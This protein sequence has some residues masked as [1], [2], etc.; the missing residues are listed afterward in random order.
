MTTQAHSQYLDRLAQRIPHSHVVNYVIF[1]RKIFLWKSYGKYPVTGKIYYCINHS[2]AAIDIVTYIVSCNYNAPMSSKTNAFLSVFIA[3]TWTQCTYCTSLLLLVHLSP[4]L[5]N[6]RV[7]MIVWRLRGNINYQNCSMLG[8]VT[9][10]LQSAAH[11]YEQFLQVQ[12]IGFVTQG[13]LRHALRRLPG[14]VLL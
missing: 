8:C 5:D 10:C 9:Q 13:P 7:M 3:Y 1:S 6:I 4:P 2:V 14:V 12:Q 11:S